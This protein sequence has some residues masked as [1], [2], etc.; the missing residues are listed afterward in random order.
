MSFESI[1]YPLQDKVLA[2]FEKAG[3]PFY[4]TGGTALSRFY[5]NHRYS[6]D[7]DFFVN[8]DPKFHEYL[9][10]LF[11]ALKR[12]GVEF[13]VKMNDE[14]FARII[15]GEGLKVE[16]VNDI[17]FYFG[18]PVKI[19]GAPYSRIDN[20]IN[21]LS[22]KITAFKDRDEAKD[23]IDIREIANSIKPDWKLIFEAADS[24]AAGV[25]PP[26][27]AEKMD[28]F[29]LDLLDNVKWIKKPD[30]TLFAQ[31]IQ[32]IIKDMLEVK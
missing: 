25:F 20:L 18:E 14:R 7:L 31:D 16:F 11:E 26:A 10:I 9:K 6:D 24:K 28:E 30:K 17:P 1:V 29:N 21:I 12:E 8:D 4:L 22:N 27:I 19:K 2:V 5:F 15:A 23:I 13:A 32:K 3:T